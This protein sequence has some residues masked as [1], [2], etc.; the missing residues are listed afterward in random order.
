MSARLWT[1]LAVSTMSLAV[2]ALAH[3]QSGA[4][5]SVNE[6]TGEA[7]LRARGTERVIF[8]GPMIIQARPSAVVRQE[9]QKL[10][11]RTLARI[12]GAL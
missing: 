2:Q 7:K 3:A 5:F 4:R 8:V 11:R 6:Q 10:E 12:G 1:A 9:R